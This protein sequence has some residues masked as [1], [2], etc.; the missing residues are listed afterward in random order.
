MR[1]M[2]SSTKYLKILI[3]YLTMILLVVVCVYILPKVIVYFMPFVV[4]LIIALITNPLVKFLERR[5]K[6]KRKAGSVVGSW[7]TV[8]SHVAVNPFAVLNVNVTVQAFF[9]LLVFLF[10]TL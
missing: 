1:Y 8:T 10:Y 7:L 2:K 5:I 6:I 3:N 4:A 9:Q